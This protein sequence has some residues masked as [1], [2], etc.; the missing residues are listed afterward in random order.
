M[1]DSRS[2]PS[3]VA[4]DTLDSCLEQLLSDQ[5]RDWLGGDCRQV[6]LY[7]ERQ[8]ALIGQ[9]DAMLELINQEIVLRRR[10]GDAPRLD[11]YLSDFPDLSG[12]LSRLFD[13]HDAISLPVRDQALAA[14]CDAED[15]ESAAGA[16]GRLP[17]I[18]GYK[19]E[20]VVGS[21]GMGVVYL[22]D[23]ETL[24]RKVALKILRYGFHD[25]TA[26]RGRFEREAAAAAKCQHPNL[27]QIFEIGEHLGEYYL[28]LE[29]VEGETL[30]TAMAGVPQ[31]PRDAA[32]LMEKLA[33]ALDHM[34]GRG[35]VHRDL[36]PAN[37]LL[38]KDGEPKITDFGLARLDDSMTRTE[39]GTLMGTLAYMAP[40]QAS[41]GS[42]EVGPAADIHALG[43]VLYEALTGRPPYRSSTPEKTLQKILFESVVPPSSFQPGIPRDLEAICLKCLEKAPNHRYATAVELAEDLRRYMDGRPTLARPLRSM[44]RLWRWSRRK[45]WVAGFFLLLSLAG[46][47][48]TWQAIRATWAEAAARK[49]RNR[50]ELARDQ[51]IAAINAIVLTD[52]DQMQSEEL[53]PYRLTMLYKGLE[54]ITERLRE[55]DDDPLGQRARADALMMQAKL[56]AASG[57]RERSAEIG[58]QAVNVLE[59]M[60]AANPAEAR[61]RARLGFLLQQFSTIAIAREDRVSA[62]Q[63]SLEICT[64]LLAQFPR[65]DQ[66]NE[67]V[68][69]ISMDLHN[70]GHECSLESAGANG[71]LWNQL[72]QKAIGAFREGERFCEQQME[73][74]ELSNEMLR[75]LARNR[76]YL[77]RAYRVLA[78][79][80]E[81]PASKASDINEAIKYGKR[82]IS[83]FQNLRERQPENYEYSWDLQIAQQELAELFINRAEGNAPETAIPYYSLARDTLKSMA[84]KHGKLVS[85]MAAIQ[86]S[87][88]L[89]DNNLLLAYDRSNVARYYDGPRRAMNA[90]IYEILDKL[91]LI[92]PLSPVQR[93]M[94]AESC[95]EMA[96]YQSYDGEEPDI[97]LVVRAERIRDEL[98]RENP[99]DNAGRGMLV[100]AR[101]Q[102][103]DL[104]EDR[105]RLAEAPVWRAKSLATAR[106]NPALFYQLATVFALNAWFAQ[107][108]PGKR[109][110]HQV[111]IRRERFI[112]HGVDMLREAVADGFRELRRLRTDPELEA[113]RSSPA[114]GDFLLD[115]QFP[116]NPL[117]P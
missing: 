106:G 18:A 112:Q 11:D 31:P 90:E 1:I 37:V 85:R 16:G 100:L 71:Q 26:H 2:D 44:T 78:E 104:L 111:E 74:T 14:E 33:R 47:G 73:R 54:L 79:R 27:V 39:L 21:G 24:K 59:G 12:P 6:R 56:L 99:T 20:R 49:Q 114:F 61:D 8:P 60:V 29:Y 63:R 48:I 92:Q 67:W 69:T 25:D 52:N 10:N 5:V 98:Y 115:A 28:A 110:G 23:D 15:G 97:S 64:A 94:Y 36:K 35:V 76:L 72:A 9:T 19:V 87:I 77:C 7:L 102:L 58:K 91:S 66:A 45:P 116:K 108:C 89:V 38:T 41:G 70:I 46:A 13:I 96:D 50:A 34:H 88:A 51:A 95:L 82:A 68:R 17:H 40:E 32:A 62:S 65:S 107:E 84:V 86:A 109:S 4:S 80:R 43:A 3:A 103:A 105:G 101:R 81:D 113:L 93:G 22:A 117:A 53:R 75:P 30:A 83:D 42:A 55:P 57:E